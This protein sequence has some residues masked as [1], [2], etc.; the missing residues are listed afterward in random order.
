MIRFLRRHLRI[1]ASWGLLC[2]IV[3]L[4][5]MVAMVLDTSPV[6]DSASYYRCIREATKGLFRLRYFRCSDHSS[7][8][9]AMLVG[10]T[11]YLSFGNVKLVYIV[12]A[13]LAAASAAAFYRLLILLLRNALSEYERSLIVG[14]SVLSP[15]FFAHLLHINLD[16]GLT[17]FFILFLSFLLHRHFWMAAA[18]GTALVFTKETGMAAYVAV[19]GLYACIFTFSECRLGRWRQTTLRFLPLLIPGLL[20]ALYFFILYRKGWQSLWSPDIPHPFSFGFNLADRAIQVYL[21]DL[22]GLNFQWLL[23]ATVCVAIVL[24]GVRFLIN[25]R[26]PSPKVDL[27]SWLFICLLFLPIL[28][29]VTRFRLWN[30]PRYVLLGSPLLLLVFAAA[31]ASL[32]SKT[33]VRSIPLSI[34]AALI[35]LSNFRT[36]DP[37]S[38]AYFGTFRFGSHSLLILTSLT[39]IDINQWYGRDDLVYNL[40]YRN[41]LDLSSDAYIAVKPTAKTLFL[42]GKWGNFFF[43]PV[44]DPQTFRAGTNF[45]RSFMPLT[46]SSTDGLTPETIKT[47]TPEP[48][49]YFIAYPNLFNALGLSALSSRFPLTDTRIFARDGYEIALYTFSTEPLRH[50]RSVPS[51]SK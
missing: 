43:P 44:V 5:I 13:L 23:T 38:K 21:F 6:W 30:N 7:L 36:I 10:F 1:P 47:Q 41:L 46:L 45:R 22:F 4:F 29:I 18:A 9:Y 25:R 40:E 32:S 12:N 49:F 3:I 28:I 31:V 51:P 50:R 24:A 15:V 42:V 35:F 14:L 8:V 48:Y 39:L 20:T 27:R 33:I 19:I 26:H 11:Q 37:L 17:C 2:V 16:F 34:I